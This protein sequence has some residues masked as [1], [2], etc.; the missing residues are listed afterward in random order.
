ML[1]GRVGSKRGCTGWHRRE[2]GMTPGR[3]EGE[4]TAVQRT[5]KGLE[6]KSREGSDG[7]SGGD[8]G[9]L[10]LCLGACVR[11]PCVRTVTPGRVFRGNL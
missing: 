4:K 6:G 9:P 2:S 1:L 7:A 3:E 10:I 8:I 11:R 5:S